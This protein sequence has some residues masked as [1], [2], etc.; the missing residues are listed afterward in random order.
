[1]MQRHLKFWSVIVFLLTIDL[2]LTTYTISN[3]GFEY[4][5]NLMVRNLTYNLGFIGIFVWWAICALF[6]YNIFLLC[7]WLESQNRF[8]I[9]HKEDL[10]ILVF[11]S[12]ICIYLLTFTS[13]IVLY[14]ITG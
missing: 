9:R 13:H 3:Y 14:M 6:Y 10:S 8:K 2:I 1:M 11:I 4:E 5:S 7:N 12:L